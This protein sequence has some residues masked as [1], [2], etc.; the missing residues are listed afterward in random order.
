[1]QT[2]VKYMGAGDYM[3][4]SSE[5]SGAEKCHRSRWHLLDTRW[6][7]NWC[8]KKNY[9]P[10]IKQNISV[11]CVC[12]MDEDA[13]QIK[14]KESRNSNL[15][16]Y[17]FGG[18]LRYDGR[19]VGWAFVVWEEDHGHYDGEIKVKGVVL[20]GRALAGQKRQHMKE[21][22]KKRLDTVCQALSHISAHL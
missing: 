4:N 11:K 9:W 6:A 2:H 1:M 16:F 18:A 19:R 22:E 8:Q 21:K 5:F 14:R 12:Q 13:N 17:R 20:P 10:G 15:Y 3:E 7:G